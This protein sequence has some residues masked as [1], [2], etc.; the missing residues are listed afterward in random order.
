MTDP[1]ELAYERLQHLYEISKLLTCFESVE[2]TLPG[3]IAVIERTLPLRCS[4]FLMEAETS[5]TPRAFVWRPPEESA[6][7]LQ[8]ALAHAE[9]AYAYLVRSGVEPVEEAAEIGSNHSY[10]LLPLVVAR[11]PIFG[12]LQLEARTTF[13]ERDLVFIN[14]V[15]NQLAIAVD[16]QAIIEARQGATESARATAET[17]RAGA[18]LKQAAAERMTEAIRDEFAFARDV[19]R[20]LGEGVIAVDLAG[21]ITLFNPAAEQL[22]VHRAQEAIGRLVREVVQLRH[23]DG[24]PLTDE[25]WP[26]DVAMRR[27]QPVRSDECLLLSRGRAAFPVNYTCAPL[28]RAGRVSGAA[29]A[30]RDIIGVK[31]AERKQRALADLGALLASS[32]SDQEI[33]A[34]IVRFTVPF[35]ADLSFIDEVGE[36]GVARRLEVVFADAQKQRELGASV[37]GFTPRPGG[38]TPQS[39]VLASGKPLLLSEVHHPAAFAH[40]DEHA[41]VIRMTGAR[42]MMVVPLVAQGATFGTLTF[43]A[44]ESGRRYSAD[45]LDLA[46][47][48]GHRVAVAI[49]NARLYERARRATCARQDVLAVVSHDL[50]NGLGVIIMNIAMLLKSSADPAAMPLLA[51]IQRSAERM[52]RLI[53]DLLDSASIEAG[54][55]SI[56]LRQVQAASLVSEVLD[57]N[58]GLATSKSIRIRS[59][60]PEALPAIAADPARLQ[61]VLTNLLTN[62]LKFTPPGGEITVRAE[63]SDDAVTFSVTDTGPGIDAQDLAHVFDRFWQVRDSASLGTG[64]GLFIVKGIVEAHGGS[65]W[66]ESTV[67]S[68][69]TFFV[70]LPIVSTSTDRR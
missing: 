31:L 60:L 21:R 3:V 29:L 16:R 48:I 55:L 30:F 52:D 54:H 8:V 47:E 62:A 64:L 67:G 9:R 26:F 35:L 63:R 51:R 41:E 66:V 12:A 38:K 36:D 49:H 11:R 23:A 14:S 4:I 58:S 44:A 27:G 34:A 24:T 1:P 28:R 59:E 10:V 40:D 46:E 43:I 20:S 70:R 57:A 6:E 45:D 33:L 32:L 69:C 18:E 39:R 17:E 15:V 7:R 68:G 53:L 56:E 22:V 19:S 50:K 13:D 42:S 65:V 37:G 2:R 5:G 61:Q 25:E